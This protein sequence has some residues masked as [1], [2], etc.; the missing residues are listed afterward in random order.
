MDDL[1]AEAQKRAMSRF[2]TVYQALSPLE[3][4]AFTSGELALDLGEG[5]S[6]EKSQF[7]NALKLSY[8]PLRALQEGQAA[9]AARAHGEH[10]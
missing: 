10:V 1:A 2:T 7:G 3:I 4:A 8:S 6:V 9:Q 5:W